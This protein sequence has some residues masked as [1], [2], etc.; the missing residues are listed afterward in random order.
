M[1]MKYLK[2]RT[3]FLSLIDKQSISLAISRSKSII[4]TTCKATTAKHA[5][6]RLYDTDGFKPFGT[7]LE[8]HTLTITRIAFSKDDR[9]VL[10]GGKDRTWHLW[11]RNED[12]GMSPGSFLPPL[13]VF[14]RIQQLYSR[15]GTCQGDLGLLL[16][17]RIGYIRHSVA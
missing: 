7:P 6:V 12:G 15:Q 3:S 9:F 13:I 5:V 2:L 8:G 4:A 17:A 11:K 10:A 1:A 14:S 16:D